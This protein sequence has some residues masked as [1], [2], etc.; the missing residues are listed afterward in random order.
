M[1]DLSTSS[2]I[3][4]LCYSAEVKQHKEVVN[5]CTCPW[6]GKNQKGAYSILNRYILGGDIYI[7]QV[8]CTSMHLELEILLAAY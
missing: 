5:N 7:I 6:R 3:K 4:I 1:Y 8:F 2:V